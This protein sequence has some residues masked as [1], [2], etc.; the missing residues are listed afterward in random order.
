M[1]D[2]SDVLSTTPA[3]YKRVQAIAEQVGVSRQAVYHWV[4]HLGLRHSVIDGVFFVADT[5]LEMFMRQKKIRR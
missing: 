2:H 1:S 5:D 4:H 3:G